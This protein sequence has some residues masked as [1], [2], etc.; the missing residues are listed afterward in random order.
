VINLLC[1]HS[2]ITA[3][4]EEQK[5]VLAGTVEAV[6]QEFELDEQQAAALPSREAVEPPSQLV[7]SLQ[8]LGQIMDRMRKGN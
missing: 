4:A 3:Y 7:G 5:P 2:L 8:N 1:E 6:A